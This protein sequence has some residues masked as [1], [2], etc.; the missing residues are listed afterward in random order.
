MENSQ[1]SVRSPSA[2]GIAAV[3]GKV[4]RS[5]RKDRFG[6]KLVAVL[7][8][9]MF[10]QLGGRLCEPGGL[11]AEGIH[12][13]LISRPNHRLGNTVLISALIIEVEALYPGA[14]IDLVGSDAT[15][16]IYSPL[17]GVHR[18]FALPGKIVRHL[19]YSAGVLRE[20]R[21][22][23]YDLAIDACNGSQSG[24]ILL[25]LVN[26]RYKLGFPD[27]GS[28]LDSDWHAFQWP[29]HL[30]HRAVFLLR[31]AYAG[32]TSQVYP[33]L[34]VL[35]SPTEI[36]QAGKMLS[37]ICIGRG[38]PG[39]G[40]VVGVFANATGAKCYGE[41]WWADFLGTFQAL[42]P[43]VRIV[44]FV[45]AHGQSNLGDRFVPFYTRNLRHLAAMAAVMDGFISA[46]CGVMHLAAASGTATLGLF[47]IT[48]PAKYAPYGGANKAIDT[49][50]VGVLD[51]AV[52]AAHWFAGLPPREESHENGRVLRNDAR[53]P[54]DAVAAAESG[55]G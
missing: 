14:E 33:P 21:S 51:A 8:R 26:A 39:P 13:V 3:P 9:R 37:C 11:P 15:D 45:A 24:K 5:S 17:F 27:R 10:R 31:K 1:K 46:D 47:S 12:R 22:C 41:K 18:V 29:A 19:W 36:A 34:R 55:A 25:S 53:S 50:N 7:F 28:G 52:D 48:D 54:H 20:I 42:C 30:A 23:R 35:L 16:T 40:R 4:H 49:R 38:Q 6:R 2:D 43:G 44:E 32:R